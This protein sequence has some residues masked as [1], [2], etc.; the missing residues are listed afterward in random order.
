MCRLIS[1][2]S[3]HVVTTLLQ[4]S[5]RF[6]CL[7]IT[8]NILYSEK[9]NKSSASSRKKAFSMTQFTYLTSFQCSILD[10]TFRILHPFTNRIH[11]RVKHFP[12]LVEF[13]EVSQ[14]RDHLLGNLVNLLVHIP[15]KSLHFHRAGFRECIHESVSRFVKSSVILFTF[16]QELL[17]EEK[18]LRTND[19]ILLRVSHFKKVS[20]R[21]S[22]VE[23]L[24]SF[25]GGC[26]ENVT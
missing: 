25:D 18:Q 24:R 2:K 4:T 22:L 21:P 7:S 9:R 10:Q 8:R 13:I 15:Q 1:A 5:A 19:M 20:L 26:N 23:S 17:V 12:L 16:F 11:Q 14:P 6:L 3:F